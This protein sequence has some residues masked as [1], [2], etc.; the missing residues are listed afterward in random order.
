[1]V[2]DDGLSELSARQERRRRRPLPP[3][4]PRSDSTNTPSQEASPA[5]R[6]TGDAVSLLPSTSPT[7][8][9]A[10]AGGIEPL[11]PPSRPQA[12]PAAP[13]R[14]PAD[15]PS[16]LRAAQHYIDDETDQAL[17]A[18]RAAGI[19]RKV[20]ITNSAVV[21]LAVQRLVDGLG[22][23]GV[24]DLLATDPGNRPRTGRKRR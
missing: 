8:P 4:F 21:R 19:V 13:Q 24:V 3:R 18:C 15:R 16:P 9:K 6:A 12:V 2:A 11:G 17:R 5:K 1:M 10:N 23:D 22:A 14:V 7:E 20:D